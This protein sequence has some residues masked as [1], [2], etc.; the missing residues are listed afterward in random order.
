MQASLKSII[1]TGSNKGIG[2]TTV[3]QI[4]EK[5]VYDKVILTARTQEKADSAIQQLVEKFSAEQV[6]SKVSPILLDLNSV[7][8]IDSFVSQVGSQFGQVDTM[9]NNAGACMQGPQYDKQEALK[10]NVGTNF[11]QT[12]ILADKVLEADLIK[13]SGLLLFVSSR[14]AK[15]CYLKELNPEYAAKLENYR[16]FNIEQFNS[17][18]DEYWTQTSADFDAKL[19]KDSYFNSK[20]FL[21]LYATALSKTE[22]IQSRDISVF[23][24]TPGFV[25]TDLNKHLWNT[26]YCPK[27]DVSHG[28]AA[29]SYLIYRDGGIDEKIQ[30]EF[31]SDVGAVEGLDSPSQYA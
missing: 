20:M 14:A 23:S 18:F 12:R 16:S 13:K 29:N 22:T 10:V 8:S 2:F 5:G 21:S 11:I 1:V 6:S 30:G 25:K 4:L 7:E 15:L 31:F 26:Q 9:L 3:C 19:W 27:D 28:G 17:V 24:F